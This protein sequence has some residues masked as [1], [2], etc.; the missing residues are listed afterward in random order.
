L[1]E[2]KPFKISYSG[3]S[4][5]QQCP[6][7][8]QFIYVDKVPTKPAPAL[9]FG[10]AIHDCLEYLHQ[11]DSGQEIDRTLHGLFEHL[12]K[13]W[14]KP[15]DFD[16]KTLE[17]AGY[18]LDRAKFLLLMY[19]ERNVGLDPGRS[20]E[21]ERALAVEKY[22]R[23]DL[24]GDIVSGLID[25]IDKIDGSYE[26]IDYKTN[27]KLP[28]DYHYE[29]DLQLPIYKWAAEEALKYSPIEKVSFFYV[30]PEINEKVTPR[31]KYDIEATKDT[32]RGVIAD[33][34]RDMAKK[35]ESGTDFEATRN[36]LCDWCD[37]Q[38]ICPLFAA[39]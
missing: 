1:P 32:V 39:K 9:F 11:P 31:V 25:R 23:A 19:F 26:V 14:S 22:F 4:A 5:Y 15:K 38:P 20:R 7:K 8:Y 12:D 18:G 6:R 17:D 10:S 3:I 36:R 29:R 24:D 37:F 21:P 34:K 27:K 2:T 35:E 30:V 28:P 16:D 33:V 13:I